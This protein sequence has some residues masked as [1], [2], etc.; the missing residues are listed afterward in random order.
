MV[1]VLNGQLQRCLPIGHNILG[2]I[3]ASAIAEGLGL[4]AMINTTVLGAYC[5][6]TGHPSVDH[7]VEAIDEMVPA[8]K[9]ENVEAVRRG[10]AQVAI[11]N[12]ER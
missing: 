7:L 9:E 3:D 2:L 10:Y 8:K 1:R 6:L 12:G 5:R 11:M 4:G